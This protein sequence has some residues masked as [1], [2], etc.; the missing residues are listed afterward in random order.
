MLQGHD[1]AEDSTTKT[2]LETTFA[3]RRNNTAANDDDVNE[4]QKKV[5]IPSHSPESVCK[6]GWTQCKYVPRCTVPQI[7]AFDENGATNSIRCT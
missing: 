4:D 7:H 2:N 3:Q 5:D 1:L 6:V